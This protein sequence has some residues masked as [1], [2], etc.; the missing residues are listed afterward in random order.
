MLSEI[1][2]DFMDVLEPFAP[3]VYDYLPERPIP[4]CISVSPGVTFIERKEGYDDLYVTNWKVQP[5]V[6]VATNKVETINL[7]AMLEDLVPAIWSIEGVVAIQVQQPFIASLN[8]A[9]FLSTFID[10]QIETN[11]Q[12]GTN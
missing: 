2:A 1:R 7:D 12:G 5:V 9:D 3:K 4:T 8:G 6:K 11:L 10:V